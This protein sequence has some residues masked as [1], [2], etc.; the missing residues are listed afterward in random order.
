MNINVGNMTRRLLDVGKYFITDTNEE[1]YLRHFS[2][3][4]LESLRELT[5]NKVSYIR[6]RYWTPDGF[7]AW[8]IVDNELQFVF[9]K[10]RAAIVTTFSEDDLTRVLLNKAMAINNLE[11]KQVVYTTDMAA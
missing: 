5:P 3:V 9:F 8:N 11:N 2:D 4:E 7:I 1:V 10:G 6:D